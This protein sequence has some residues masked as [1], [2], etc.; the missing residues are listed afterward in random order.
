MILSNHFTV[1]T[2]IYSYGRDKYQRFRCSDFLESCAQVDRPL[3][4]DIIKDF[5][6]SIGPWNSVGLA[7]GMEN[8]VVVFF[9]LRNSRHEIYLNIII[10]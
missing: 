10:Q 1:F 9:K 2:A 3:I 4:V 8:D 7:A 5:F 6:L